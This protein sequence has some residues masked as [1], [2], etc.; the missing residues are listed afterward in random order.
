[1]NAVGVLP[2]MEVFKSKELSIELDIAS[3]SARLDGMPDDI[4]RP[5]QSIMVQTSAVIATTLKKLNVFF[6]AIFIF[7]P[8]KTECRTKCIYK[9]I[10]QQ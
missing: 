7:F 1:M 8:N 9:I 3:L 5:A 2:L 6:S 10:Q 4:Q